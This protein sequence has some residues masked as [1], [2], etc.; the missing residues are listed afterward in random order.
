MNKHIT[1]R[2]FVV[3]EYIFYIG[4]CETQKHLLWITFDISY[5]IA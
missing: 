1:E 3:I 2:M 4:N 5:D